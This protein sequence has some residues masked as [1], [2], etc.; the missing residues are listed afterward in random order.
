MS[1][2]EEG[3]R[4]AGFAMTV[5]GVALAVF[6]V[7]QTRALFGQEPYRRRVWRWIKELRGIF[8]MTRVIAGTVHAVTPGLRASGTATVRSNPKYMSISVRL[9]AVE[10]NLRRVDADLSSTQQQFRDETRAIRQELARTNAEQQTGIAR[11]A[12]KLKEYST[13]SLD[14]ELVGAVWVVIGQAYGS[15]PVEIANLLH[16]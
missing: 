7:V 6:G 14:L 16:H 9:R 4:A 3:V 11:V 12:E 8:G 10:E 15:F 5:A 2:T 13:G 1:S